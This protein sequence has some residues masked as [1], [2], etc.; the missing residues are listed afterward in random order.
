LRPTQWKRNYILKRDF[1]QTI[2]TISLRW[3]STVTI[4]NKLPS[5]TTKVNISFSIQY[6]KV[7]IN[8]TMMILLNNG[9]SHISKIR[10][11][12]HYSKMR[13]KLSKLRLLKSIQNTIVTNRDKIFWK[14]SGRFKIWIQ[15]E[16]FKE[17]FSWGNKKFCSKWKSCRLRRFKSRIRQLEKQKRL[18]NCRLFESP[19]MMQISKNLL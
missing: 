11:M 15:K 10:T 2:C 7:S 3:Q 5:T 4:W 9:L 16:A 18:S 13:N 14:D 6:I 12:V 8:K 19:F 17:T 1:S